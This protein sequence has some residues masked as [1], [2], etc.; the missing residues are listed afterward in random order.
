MNLD[1]IVEYEPAYI[2]G[3]NTIVY[4]IVDQEADAFVTV[5]LTVVDN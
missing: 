4:A 5:T 2:V 3:I 1:R